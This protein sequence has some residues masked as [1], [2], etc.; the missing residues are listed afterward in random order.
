MAADKKIEEGLSFQPKFDANGLITAISQDADSGQ[1]LMVAYM[2][3]EALK[4]TLE[5]GNA[6][7][8]SRSRQKLWKKGEQS[9]HMQKVQQILVDCDQD[10]LILKVKVDQGQCHVGYQSCF[11][12]AVKPGTTNELEFVAEKVYDPNEAYKK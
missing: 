1:V 5:T 8:F 3:D 2:N 10:C 9:G 4:L 6:V 7:F 11:Y 12:R